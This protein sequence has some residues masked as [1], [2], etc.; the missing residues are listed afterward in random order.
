M[1]ALG[2]IPASAQQ[3]RPAPRS[4]VRPAAAYQQNAARQ[5]EN[6][7]PFLQVPSPNHPEPPELQT[8]VAGP[9]PGARGGLNLAPRRRDTVAPNYWVISFRECP[10]FGTPYRADELTQYLHF[11]PT[12]EKQVKSAD[13]FYA[14][15]RP[16]VPLCMMV[17]G[18]L[19]EWNQM[20]GEGHETFDWLSKAANGPFQMVFVTWP[21]ERILVPLPPVDFPMLGKQ[22]GYNGLYLARVLSKMPSDVRIS[23]IGHSHGARMVVSALHLTGGGDVEGFRMQPRDTPWPRMRGV[24]AAAA[25]DHH[26]L[27]PDQR[28]DHALINTESLLNFRNRDDF[29]LRMYPLRLPFGRE[30]LGRV[31][32]NSY[33]RN[34]LGSNYSKVRDVEVTSVLGVKHIWPWFYNQPQIAQMLAPYLFFQEDVPPQVTMKPQSH[35]PFMASKETE[36]Y[37]TKQRP[38]SPTTRAGKSQLVRGNISTEPPVPVDREIVIPSE[39]GRSKVTPS[40]VRIFGGSDQRTPRK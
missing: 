18:S 20:L 40:A 8:E 27:D 19:M 14:S 6:S 9:P 4:T 37:A 13:E 21:S 31:G 1:L 7:G 3:G 12:G 10:Q 29:A 16:D 5:S 15:L 32:F 26:W 33:D 39:A 17:H 25:F 24:L 2:H 34:V 38:P 23:M 36:A 28:Y 11:G 22:G 30:S 35:W